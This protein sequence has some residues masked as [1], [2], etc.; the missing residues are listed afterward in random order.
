MDRNTVAVMK[1]GRV[2]GHVSF[3]LTPIISLFLRRDVNNA[4]A[5]V[6]GGNVNPGTDGLETIYGPKPYVDKIREV[7]SFSE[8]IWT[9][10]ISVHR[11]DLRLCR[12]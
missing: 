10:L 7:F 2:V 9:R 3:N 11:L 12:C 1:E 5:R 6:T 8:D 4:F